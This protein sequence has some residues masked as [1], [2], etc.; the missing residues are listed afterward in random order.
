MIK[1]YLSLDDISLVPQYST[2]RH[3]A[4][5]DVSVKIKNFTF[6]HPIIVANM[7]DLISLTM[8]FEVIE[9]G[10]LA[11]D[12][13]FQTPEEQLSRFNEC[14][15]QYTETPNHFG[16]SIGIDECYTDLVKK[17]IN[18]GGK[19]ICLDVAHSHSEHAIEM[20]K[21]VSKFAKD[22]KKEILFIAGNVATES[23]ARSMFG[24]GADICKVGI[25]NGSTCTT[26]IVSGHGLPSFTALQNIYNILPEFNEK[27]IIADGGLKNSGDCVKSLIYSNFVMT[28]NL[29]SASKES[30][31][32][33]FEG[34]DIGLNP[35]FRYKL[36]RG[37]STHKSK[38][39]EGVETYIK[40]KGSYSEIL[41]MLLQGIRSGCSY[42]NAHNL[43]QL[44]DDPQWVK[45]S[46]LALRE[47]YPHDVDCI[48]K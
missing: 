18:I 4:D 17:F 37:S 2:V 47:A 27:Y 26:R 42:Q 23:G 21:F 44:R 39:K 13:R 5:V 6:K 34:K 19:I 38:N 48:I 40:T 28:G 45:I 16:I 46:A 30:N 15:K 29:F 32:I 8:L 22:S 12:H 41:D 1:E 25:S 9:S 24:F 10:G 3:R 20:I 7:K 43:S 31:G 35:R 36:Y 33:V 11:I 14:L